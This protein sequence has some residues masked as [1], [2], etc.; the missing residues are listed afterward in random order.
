MASPSSSVAA[1]TCTPVLEKPMTGSVTCIPSKSGTSTGVN[2]PV[3]PASVPPEAS[4]KP[5]QTSLS[6]ITNTPS[7]HLVA[8]SGTAGIHAVPRSSFGKPSQSPLAFPQFVATVSYPIHSPV[9]ASVNTAAW[10]LVPGSHVSNSHNSYPR[11]GLLSN[12][13]YE[14]Y[15]PSPTATTHS[16]ATSISS[17]IPGGPQ[18]IFSTVTSMVTETSQS[19]L[20]APVSIAETTD[21]QPTVSVPPSITSIGV[22][23]MADGEVV[24]ATHVVSSPVHNTSNPSNSHS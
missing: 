12:E 7:G 16:T 22:T 1:G 8:H 13:P 24:S 4:S 14:P 23:T 2:H 17:G 15:K 9:S 10:P 20:P 3:L 11:D 21:G 5:P 18:S 19:T 6:V